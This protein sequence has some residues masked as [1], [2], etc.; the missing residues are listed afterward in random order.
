[1][2]EQLTPDVIMQ[3]VASGKPYTVLMLIP[4]PVPPPADD[5]EVNIFQMGHLA[6]LFTLEAQGKISVF[7][8]VLNDARFRGIIVFNTAERSEVEK[9]MA[10][11][12]WVKGGYLSYELYD[13]FSIPGQTIAAY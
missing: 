8:P 9:L 5:A 12:P 2:T 4:G 11:D 13:W 1:M 6:H 7:G 10:T 3:K